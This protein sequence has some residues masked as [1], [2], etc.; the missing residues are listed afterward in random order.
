MRWCVLGKR[1]THSV[2][3]GYP[4]QIG[5]NDEG[6]IRT[7][8]SSGL[9]TDERAIR[10][11]GQS[12]SRGDVCRTNCVPGGGI[13]PP[14][15]TARHADDRC[16]LRSWVY[17]GRSGRGGG[18]GHVVGIDFQPTQIEQARDLAAKRAVA[19]VRFEVADAYRVPFP[20]H[21]FDAAFAHAVLTHLR[22]PVRALVETGARFAPAA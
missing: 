18:P 13:L 7:G 9:C 3:E 2:K 12:W 4:D 14:I 19:N 5:C 1:K 6:R 17:H 11:A 16:R 8:R 15:L 10:P 20:D 21:S 22:E